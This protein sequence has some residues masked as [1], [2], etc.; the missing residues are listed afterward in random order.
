MR[1]YFDTSAIRMKGSSILNTIDSV[2][3]TTSILTAIE[4]IS[5]AAENEKEFQRV[6]PIFR[7]F[8][9][10]SFE[11]DWRMPEEKIFSAFSSL[12]AVFEYQ[13]HRTASLIQYLNVAIK[14][15]SNV[16]FIEMCEGLKCQY[17]LR[18]FVDYDKMFGRQLRESL[19]DDMKQIKNIFQK[20]GGQPNAFPED[21][22][23]QIDM[24]Y[25]EMWDLPHMRQVLLYA[26]IY[27]MVHVALDFCGQVGHELAEEEVYDSYNQSIE[28]F[29]KAFSWIMDDIS[30]NGRTMGKNDPLDLAHFLY[31]TPDSVLLTNDGR[32]RQVAKSIGVMTG[33][34]V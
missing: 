34:L 23:V 10:G 20:H 31:L 6:R 14:A 4:L 28:V 5:A 8:F 7:S 11:I 13:E 24:G 12:N 21:W 18:Y 19:S 17:S 27:G 33:N 15:A 3:S 9:D 32:M 30:K 26:T 25:K 29:I 22:N 2:N 1:L 16:L